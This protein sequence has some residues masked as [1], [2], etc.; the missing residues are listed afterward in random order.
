MRQKSWVQ[1][2]ESGDRNTAFFHSMIKNQ[3]NRKRIVSLLTPVGVHTKGEEEAK[4][5]AICYFKSLLGS[6]PNNPYP[7][8]D[9]LRP[10]I[11]KRVSEEHYVLLDVIPTDEEI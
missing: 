8:A 1:W 4:I 6:P 3:R 5:E 2:L 11:H 10:F 9:V 7:G